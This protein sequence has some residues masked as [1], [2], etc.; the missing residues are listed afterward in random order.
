M[1]GIETLAQD[2]FANQNV[3]VQPVELAIGEECYVIDP[4]MIDMDNNFYAIIPVVVIGITTSTRF[5]DRKYYQFRAHESK[6]DDEL[7]VLLD[8]ENG[9]YYRILENTSPYIIKINEVIDP[10][11]QQNNNA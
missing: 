7:N 10:Q 8:G 2:F 5:P 6:A 1:K 4:N 9:A 3:C 11:N